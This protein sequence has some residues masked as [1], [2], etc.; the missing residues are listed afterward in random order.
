MDPAPTDAEWETI[1]QRHGASPLHHPAIH[2]SHLPASSLS[3]LLLQRG[4]EEVG[5]ALA[6]HHEERK[7]R[8]PIGR[9]K[10]LELPSAPALDTNVDRDEAKRGLLGYAGDCDR[11]VI[12]GSSSDWL[13]DDPA[14]SAY[15]DDAILEFVHELTDDV[16]E[17]RATFHKVHRKNARRANKRG[18]EVVEDSSLEGMLVLRTM[19]M[20]SAE[21]ARERDNAFGVREEEFFHTLHREVYAPGLGHLFLARHE[22]KPIAAL[23]WIQLGKRAQTVRSGSTPEGYQNYAMYG[24]YD[25]L[26]ERLVG[27]GVRELNGG[28]VPAEAVAEGHPQHGLYEFKKG[29]GGAETLR[30]TL[31]LPQ[32]AREG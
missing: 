20:A 4:G 15:R 21:R 14:F 31:D 18:V 28:G 6:L 13:V 26:V 2:R 5:C 25:A 30:Y 3:Y 9:K 23:A 17:V 8:L 32:A 27:E 10:I 11:L 12:R 22:G 19:Q 1:L 24:L 7:L 29:Y 16:D